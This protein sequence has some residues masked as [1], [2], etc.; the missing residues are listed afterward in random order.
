[1]F[2]VSKTNSGMWSKINLAAG[3]APFQFNL[4]IRKPMKFY[5][6]ITIL[7]LIHTKLSVCD[8]KLK[9]HH[10]INKIICVESK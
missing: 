2:N 10:Y 1:M 3:K 7:Y 5:P 9:L 4:G 8:M 6:G